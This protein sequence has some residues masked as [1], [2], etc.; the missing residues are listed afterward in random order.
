MC[1]LFQMIF[2]LM[3]RLDLHAARE[4]VLRRLGTSCNL[5]ASVARLHLTLSNQ[6]LVLKLRELNRCVGVRGQLRCVRIRL[7]AAIVQAHWACM[8]SGMPPTAHHVVVVFLMFDYVDI[9]S[10]LTMTFDGSQSRFRVT[11][12]LPMNAYLMP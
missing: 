11:A 1:H 4:L 7:R 2:Q 9:F 3:P 12:I 8:G 6:Q 5:L 10:S